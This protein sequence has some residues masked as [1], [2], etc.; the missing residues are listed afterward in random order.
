[1]NGYGYGWL[2]KTV[3]LCVVLCASQGVETK[4]K[5]NR[6]VEGEEASEAV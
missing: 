1:M 2:K 4:K 6:R 5:K 3:C